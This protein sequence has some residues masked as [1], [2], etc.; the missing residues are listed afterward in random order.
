[1]TL[2]AASPREDA[3]AELDAPAATCS[4]CVM[5]T[6]DPDIVIY[7]DGSCNHCRR[8]FELE[9]RYPAPGPAR[10]AALEALVD[11]IRRAGKGHDYDCVI[12][13]SGGVDST[14]VAYHVRRLGLRPIALHLDNGWNSEL[15]VDNIKRTLEAL[16][17]DLI[18]HVIDWNEFRDI[19][20]SFLRASVPNCEIPSDHAI[21]ALLL[22]RAAKMGVKYVLQGTNYATEG[23]LPFA[24]TYNALDYRHLRAIHRRFGTERLRTFPTLSLPRFAWLTVVRGIKYIPFLNYVDYSRSE[25]KRILEDELGWRDYGGKHYE[26]LYTKFYQYYILPKKFGFDKRRAHLAA[27]VCAGEI[28]R[29]EALSVLETQPHEAEDFDADREYVVKKLGLTDEQFDEILA[30]PPRPH[31]SFPGYHHLFSPR[32][33]LRRLYRRLVTSG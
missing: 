27:L 9:Q 14:T 5:D 7:A 30:Q 13:V 17:I 2:P 25:S 31:E 16:S 6:S 19:Q 18:T 3:L 33:P 21:N 29:E 8:Y 12:G 24:W 15:A 22:S 32:S 23:I 11:R 20:V 10:E 28:E 26:S 1:M 4:R